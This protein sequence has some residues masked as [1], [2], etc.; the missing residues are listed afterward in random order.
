MLQVRDNA[1]TFQMI[2][3]TAHKE[4]QI[5][6]LDT[7]TNRTM[8][9]LPQYD[10]KGNEVDCAVGDL[11]LVNMTGVA[12]HEKHKLKKTKFVLYDHSHKQYFNSNPECC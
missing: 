4:H 11:K 2:I 7:S 6:F 9:A 5:T 1:T 10:S 3:N 12:N 8:V